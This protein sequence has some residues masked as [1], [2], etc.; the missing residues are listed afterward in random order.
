MTAYPADRPGGGT[1][2]TLDPLMDGGIMPFLK[3]LSPPVC[4]VRCARIPPLTPRV[5]LSGHRPHAWQSWSHGL[6]PVRV[7]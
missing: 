4:V 6:L 5:D 1:F 2:A 7:P 3:N